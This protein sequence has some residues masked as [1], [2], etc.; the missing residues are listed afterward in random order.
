LNQTE[1]RQIDLAEGVEGHSIDNNGKPDD[2]LPC[3]VGERFKNGLIEAGIVQIAL[4]R[5]FRI[6][7]N[8][9][10]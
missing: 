9:P 6:Y 1:L 3:V 7:F 5:L 8:C 10:N 4:V 2:N